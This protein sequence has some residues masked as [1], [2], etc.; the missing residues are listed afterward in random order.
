MSVLHSLNDGS[1][2]RTM[3]ARELITYSP[4]QGN[5]I[6]DTKHVDALESAIGGHCECLDSGYKLIIM[7]EMDASETIIENKYIIDGQHR[8]EVIKRGFKNNPFMDDFTVL[9][10][11]KRVRGEAEAISYFRALNHAKPIEWKVDPKLII[12]KYIEAL[13]TGFMQNKRV[14]FIRN[15]TKFPYLS[16]SVL[17]TALEAE[18]ARSPLS[19]EDADVVAF[20]E[21]VLEWNKAQILEPVPPSLSKKIRD[22]LEKGIAVGF[23]LAVD[24]TCPWIRINRSSV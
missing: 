10:T 22:R 3:S 7:R 14:S 17:R 1:V 21:K 11:E 12:N 9:V 15:D 6:L 8:A 16:A 2:L 13:E 23:V 20:V 4:W 19:D 18:Y 24:P 5:R